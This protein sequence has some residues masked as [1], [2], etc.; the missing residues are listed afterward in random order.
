M[1]STAWKVKSMGKN[2]ICAN[3]GHTREYHENPEI[4]NYW[5]KC[6]KFIEGDANV[7]GDEYGGK[8]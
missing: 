1:T 8:E 7:L 6:R 2:D 5:C 3:C 4:H